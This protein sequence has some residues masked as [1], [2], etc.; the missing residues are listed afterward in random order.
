[1]HNLKKNQENNLKLIADY[2]T[3]KN[4]NLQASVARAS[5]TYLGPNPYSVHS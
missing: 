3:R 2:E 4:K 5:P 1:M